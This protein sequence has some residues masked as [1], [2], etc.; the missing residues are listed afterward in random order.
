MSTSWLVLLTLL[1]PLAAALLITIFGR[2]PNLR[3]AISPLAG[4]VITLVVILLYQRF[5]VGTRLEL[6]LLEPLP[7]LPCIPGTRRRETSVP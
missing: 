1:I 6:N 3:D 5:Q 7:G 2:W 4:G